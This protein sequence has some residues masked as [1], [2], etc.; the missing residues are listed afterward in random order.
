[1][2]YGLEVTTT[3]LPDGK[4]TLTVD[5]F[6]PSFREQL[7]RRVVDTQEKQIREAL[8]KLG[9]TPPKDKTPG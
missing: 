8:I 5:V 9:W 2:N 6:G 1:M 7:M 4:I 3:P